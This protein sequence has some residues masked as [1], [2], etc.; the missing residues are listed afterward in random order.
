M[1]LPCLQFVGWMK[2][3]GD[4]ANSSYRARL[5]IIRDGNIE[6]WAAS[7]FG[8]SG[9]DAV[10]ENV[11]RLALAAKSFSKKGDIPL[12]K[13]FFIE[14]TRD[15]PSSKDQTMSLVTATRT[16]EFMAGSASQFNNFVRSAEPKCSEHYAANIGSL[17]VKGEIEMA[18][19][20]MLSLV[21][22]LD[23]GRTFLARR[24]LDD[25]RNMH[26]ALVGK[27]KAARRGGR[28]SAEQDHQASQVRFPAD[29]RAA[30]GEDGRARKLNAYFVRLLASLSK[31]ALKKLQAQ[32]LENAQEQR[33]NMVK[34]LSVT[35]GKMVSPRKSSVAG[36]LV[37]DDED[38]GGG[39]GGGGSKI[40]ATIGLFR[41]A[42]GAGG[43]SGPGDGGGAVAAVA[44]SVRQ[45][46]T[47]QKRLMENVEA[48]L[49]EQQQ[50]QETLHD[51]VDHDDDEPSAARGGGGRQAAAAAAAATPGKRAPAREKAAVWWRASSSRLG[52]AT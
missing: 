11:D 24:S 17:K 8:G 27:P 7:T 33:Q 48:I 10:P 50:M 3:R 5:V 37:E 16:F 49:E 41:G 46:A 22:A 39:G 18:G 52:T 1:L 31:R 42:D 15:S 45:I 4:S 13:V 44:R 26:E 40:G 51:L 34:R 36:G 19:P 43:G 9:G 14:D 30:D 12:A 29:V 47:G 35:V 32:L 21:V 25:L 20:L 6:Y 28:S 38:D 2:K 23:S